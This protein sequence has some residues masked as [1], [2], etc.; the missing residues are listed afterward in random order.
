VYH[1]APPAIGSSIVF[2]E[3]DP[4]SQAF[5]KFRVSSLLWSELMGSPLRSN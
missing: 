4:P 3:A 5:E 2:G 1:L